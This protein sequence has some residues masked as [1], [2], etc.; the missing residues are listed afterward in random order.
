[1]KRLGHIALLGLTILFLNA[2]SE[3]ANNYDNDVELTQTELQT[4]LET[5]DAAG[6]V[7]STLAEL[8]SANGQASKASNASNECYSVEYSDTGY[9]ATFNNCVLNGT[10]NINGTLTVT[11]AVENQSAAFTATYEDFYVGTL[12]LNGIRSYTLNTDAEQGTISFTVISD[13]SIEKEDESI[14]SE[15]GT[16]TFGF[17]FGDGLE[18][19]YF[20]IS[21]TWQVEADGDT[22]IV[23]TSTDLTGSLTC[24]HLTAG[25]MD[26][27][28]NGF[29]IQ[30]DFG[31][32][33]CDNIAAVTLPNGTSSEVTL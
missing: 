1:M 13:I 32:G 5:D 21:G 14:I 4:I 10:E 11:Y 29:T 9:V 23:E 22:Y 2:C 20:S 28:K 25:S 3:D 16:K 30:V 31:D 7:D 8:F 17:I 15:S 19:S 12:K 24:E 26:V 6:A 33:T 27:N 18:D